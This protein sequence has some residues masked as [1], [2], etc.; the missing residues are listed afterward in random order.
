MAY[1]RTKKETKEWKN[2]EGME[3]FSVIGTRD[4]FSINLDVT[5]DLRIS[6]NGCRVV[7]GKNGLFISY[8]AWK[9]KEGNYHNHC[10]YTFSPEEVQM[11]AKALD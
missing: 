11:I 6:M 8:P 4:R 7:D 1:T 2:V 10:Y 9:D 3:G 5:D